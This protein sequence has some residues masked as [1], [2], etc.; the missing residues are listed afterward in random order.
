MRSERARARAPKKRSLSRRRALT[1]SGTFASL[2]S[3]SFSSARRYAGE[4]RK[5]LR[6]GEGVLWKHAICTRIEAEWVNDVPARW[7]ARE[8]C[9][10]PPPDDGADDGGAHDSGELC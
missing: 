3:C 7:G 6:H 9:P 10:P 5:G 1:S 4:W 8:F 2:A